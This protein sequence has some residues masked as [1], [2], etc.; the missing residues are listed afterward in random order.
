[1]GVSTKGG[2]N[3][4]Y[5]S[6]EINDEQLGMLDDLEMLREDL[7]GEL[8][9]INQYHGH[10]LI[11]EN[12]EAVTTLGY[13]IEEKKKHVAELLRLIQNLDPIQAEKFKEIL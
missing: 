1:M 9:A 4:S 5:S 12:E 3:M 7:V 2:D 10:V 8:Q 6:E 13:I 11:L